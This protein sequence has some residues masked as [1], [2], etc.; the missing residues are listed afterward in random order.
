M[1]TSRPHVLLGELDRLESLRDPGR[2][3]LRTFRRF[4]IRGD[5][6]LHPMNRN[7]LD[8]TPIEIKLR[9][10]SRGGLGF[11]CSQPLPERS[12]WR[13]TFLQH[14][15]VVGM[16]A[17]MIRHSRQVSDG[18]YL[19]G[20]QFVIDSGLMITLGIPRSAMEES[21]AIGPDEADSEEFLSPGEVED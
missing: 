4:V 16:Q 7:R 21:S 14:G 8:P 19:V 5:A 20:G 6:E 2:Q 18:V 12:S 11:I 3:G 9:D 17:L 13:V 1:S 15:Y 10:L